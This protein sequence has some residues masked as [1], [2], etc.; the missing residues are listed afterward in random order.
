MLLT[1]AWDSSDFELISTIGRYD[2]DIYRALKTRGD[3]SLNQ[4]KD[5]SGYEKYLSLSFTPDRKLGIFALITAQAD[6]LKQR[7]EL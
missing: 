4:T 5:A 7:L 6:Y 3:K 1:D 2:G